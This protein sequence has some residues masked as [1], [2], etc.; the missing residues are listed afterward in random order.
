M[1]PDEANRL[2]AAY[3]QAIA[4]M[5]PDT[6]I[7]LAGSASIPG[8]AADDVDLVVLVHDV[9]SAAAT[10]RASYPPL[11]E[12]QWGDEW[13]AFR[14]AGH[15]SVD[16]VLT[17]RGT[18]W[19]AHHRRA[20]TLLREDENLLLEYKAL[21]AVPG[22]YDERKAEFFERLVRLLPPDQEEIARGG[23]PMTG[24]AIEIREFCGGRPR[25]RR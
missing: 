14:I 13:A 21:K 4:A 2:F 3:R 7:H 10:L 22:R 18:K 5:L 23:L 9:R 6:E 19:D 17:R 20:W 15:P 11:Y 8:L 24:P 16:V 12:Q 25:C 1:D